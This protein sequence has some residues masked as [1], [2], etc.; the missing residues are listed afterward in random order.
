MKGVEF[1]FFLFCKAIIDKR[2]ELKKHFEETPEPN[3]SNVETV[4]L[5]I[6]LP[7]GSRHQRI[8]RR[9]DPL[10]ELYNFVFAQEE[11]P[12][13]FEIAINFPRKVVE[14]DAATARTIDDFG[15]T[16]SMLLFVNDLDA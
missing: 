4:K 15:I 5:V 10:S 11:C 6:K 14:C 2:K 12:K 7:S 13:N 1:Y 3:P 9:H 16:Q 8:F